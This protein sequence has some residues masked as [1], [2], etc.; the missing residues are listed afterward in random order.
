MIPI[1]GQTEVKGSGV[2][3][4]ILKN[5]DGRVFSCTCPAWRNCGGHVDRKTCKHLRSVLGNAHEDARV[6]GGQPAAP[7]AAAPTAAPS[8]RS[9]DAAA[10]VARAEAA[11]R[12]LRPDEKAKLN[13]PPILLA[14]K[15]EDAGV[16]PTGWWVSEK[17]DGV[18]AYWDGE[19][20]V[21]RQGN[22][23]QAPA[24]FKEGLPREKLDGE[25]WI[26]RKMFQRTIS[27][28][29][30]LDAG[31]A[32]REVRYLIYDSPDHGGP[33]EERVEACRRAAGPAHFAHALPHRQVSSRKWLLDELKEFVAA[34]A[35]GLMIRKPGSL[36]EVGRSHTLL[37]VK[38]FQDAE[39]VVVGHTPGKGR[40]K[41]VLGALVLRL[42][43]GKEFS[44]G[45][46]L[47]DAERR[48]PPRVGATVTYSFT[49]LTDGG[50]PK[51]A[52]FV[53]VRD[54]E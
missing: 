40:H 38:P 36:Y 45:T 48:S 44:V 18:R 23:Y 31:E 49:E 15:F 14:H 51:C 39:A 1:G 12:K 8:A 2:K 7:A 17:L 20:F 27:V 6:S 5:H 52:A 10:T 13:G 19:N 4:Y 16:D 32:W 50:I 53:A 33:F 28:V 22:V 54:Y 41:G 25:L 30:Q 35:E 9:A 11:G 42:P 37:K 24:W 3:P 34:G 47:T 43:D 26:G 21:S 46:G 29:R